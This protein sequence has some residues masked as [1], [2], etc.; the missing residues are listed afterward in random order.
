M[1]DSSFTN[2]GKWLNNIHYCNYDNN[3][4]NEQ[5]ILN[6]FTI[7]IEKIITNCPYCGGEFFHKNGFSLSKKS[8]KKQQQYMCDDCSKTFTRYTKIYNRVLEIRQEK[9][10]HDKRF[11]GLWK[12]ALNSFSHIKVEEIY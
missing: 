8:Q 5:Q 4:K 11:I 12:Q 10:N 3:R 1:V 6:L 7:M 9:E 2:L